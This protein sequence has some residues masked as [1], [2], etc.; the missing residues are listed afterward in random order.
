MFGLQVVKKAKERKPKRKKE[1]SKKVLVV[2][3]LLG[4]LIIAYA[5]F[6]QMLII[7]QNYIGDSSI[8]VALISGAFAE[9]GLV[10]SVYKIKAM[11]ENK[12]KLKK[13]YGEEF[14]NQIEYEVEQ[15][16][17]I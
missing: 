16:E 6:I 2:S 3:Y 13:I 17:Y 15:E 12:I 7:T 4:V 1:F 5:M 10:T 11:Q 14:V 8:V 9:M